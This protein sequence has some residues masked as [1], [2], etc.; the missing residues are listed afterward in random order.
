M[1]SLSLVCYNGVVIQ[2]ADDA[3][4]ILLR[5][6]HEDS[7][8][9]ADSSAAVQSAVTAFWTAAPTTFPRFEQLKELLLGKYEE[10]TDDVSDTASDADSAAS[11]SA[12]ASASASVSPAM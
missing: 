11:V 12:S 7:V 5:M 9:F 6:T 3:A 4:V 2:E 8:P 10:G 1:L